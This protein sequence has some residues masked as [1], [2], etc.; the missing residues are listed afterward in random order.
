[1]FLWLG[2]NLKKKKE[3]R[4]NERFQSIMYALKGKEKKVNINYQ[5]TITKSA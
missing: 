5:M 4:Q 1:M 2:N 3:R